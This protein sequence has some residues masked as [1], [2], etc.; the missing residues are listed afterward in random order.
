MNHSYND[1][2][3]SS[4]D[5]HQ[6]QRLAEMKM[7]RLERDYIMCVQQTRTTI[8]DVPVDSKSAK[9]EESEPSISYYSRLPTAGSGTDDDES[10]NSTV[11]VDEPF[12]D[13]LNFDEPPTSTSD[14]SSEVAKTPRILPL[15][16]NT[17]SKIKSLVSG[18]KI[19]PPQI[20]W[21][22]KTANGEIDKEF[23]QFVVDRV[24]N[25]GEEDF[26]SFVG[27]HTVEDTGELEWVATFPEMSATKKKKKKRK[28]KKQKKQKN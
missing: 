11:M 10:S 13:D 6:V 15:K 25:W 20:N 18:M 24:N 1:S 8:N 28:K 17:V 16:D 26:G 12:D 2:G 27:K 9:T 4:M 3:I 14:D 7:D 21:L 23:D 22:P 19:A 5:M